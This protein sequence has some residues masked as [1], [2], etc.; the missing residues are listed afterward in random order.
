MLDRY[1]FIIIL[2]SIQSI[3]YNQHCI[4]TKAWVFILICSTRQRVDYTVAV[5]HEQFPLSGGEPIAEI[6]HLLFFRLQ[7]VGTKIAEGI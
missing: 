7:G 6:D 5:I 2:Q 1:M 4:V 3:I